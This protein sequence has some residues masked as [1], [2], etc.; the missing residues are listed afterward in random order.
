MDATLLVLGHQNE[1][2]KTYPVDTDTMGESETATSS[3]VKSLEEPG[4][5]AL[6][7]RRVRRPQEHTCSSCVWEGNIL[8]F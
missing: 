5:R 4:E 8:S 1:H 3:L 7:F 2:V 6:T